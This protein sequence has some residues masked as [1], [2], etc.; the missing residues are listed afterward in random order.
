MSAA[1]AT[2]GSADSKA[3][4]ALRLPR[5]PKAVV[6]ASATLAT[7]VLLALLA[8]LIRP[9]DANAVNL[10]AV[11]ESPSP[12]HPMGTDENGRDLLARVIHGLRVSF[13]VAAVASLASVSLG[14]V[15]GVLAGAAG[16]WVDG[17]L[18][19]V[20]DLFA[21][22]NH[23]LFGVLLAVLFRPV[24]GGAGAV[25]LAV[26]LTHW[27]TLARIVRGELLSLRE[28]SFVAAAVG[29]GASRARLARRHFLPHLLP[30]IV[31]GF[32]L[33]FPHAIFHESALSFLGIG[34]SPEQASLGNIIADGQRSLLAGGW[35]VSLFPGALILIVTLSVGTVGEY[36]RDRWQP[37][38]RS[39]LEL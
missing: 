25:M 28:R 4:R 34:L 6:A 8:G 1:P 38:W 23:L 39:E 11:L 22:Q 31:L 33:T 27:P 18:M 24:L 7:L 21:S 29:G 26:G 10:A 19:R 36:L 12:A 13:A 30:T 32:V 5:A 37:R 35:W 15:V 3:R 17:A 2:Q 9:L 16:G 14:V 20:V